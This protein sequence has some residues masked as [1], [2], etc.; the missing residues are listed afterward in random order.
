MRKTTSVPLMFPLDSAIF[1]MLTGL[2]RNIC[3]LPFTLPFAGVGAAFGTMAGSLRPK[4]NSFQKTVLKKISHNFVLRNV[5]KNCVVA[6][7][8]CFVFFNVL[9]RIAS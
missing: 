9:F 2:V 4:I 6:D 1:D 5:L 7:V 8:I 3:I